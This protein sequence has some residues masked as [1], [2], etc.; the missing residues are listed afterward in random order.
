MKQFSLLKLHMMNSHS[1]FHHFCA[2]N[3]Y[4]NDI[5]DREADVNINKH[6]NKSRTYL[7]NN[8]IRI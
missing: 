2:C 3:K 4:C 8:T 6:S 1:N 5:N 7:N